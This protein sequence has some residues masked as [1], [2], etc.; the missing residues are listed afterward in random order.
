MNNSV[1]AGQYRSRTNAQ[2]RTTYPSRRGAQTYSKAPTGSGVSPHHHQHKQLLHQPR[3]LVSVPVEFYD[4]YA[5]AAMS[6]SE[7]AARHPRQVHRASS[8]KP[9]VRHQVSASK[10]SAG[11]G[12]GSVA[13]TQLALTAARTSSPNLIYYHQGSGFFTITAH[14]PFDGG[15]RLK[16]S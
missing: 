14:L 4:P 7:T 6:V 3:S 9:S 2:S 5:A 13:K 10:L 8:P 16:V 11:G 12:T 1:R 15:K